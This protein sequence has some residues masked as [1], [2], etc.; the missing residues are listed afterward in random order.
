MFILFL[1][2]LYFLQV[3][4]FP[5]VWGPIP[6]FKLTNIPYNVGTTLYRKVQTTCCRLYIIHHILHNIE[7][8]MA[9]P[10]N[11]TILSLFAPSRFL[12]QNNERRNNKQLPVPQ[13][14]KIAVS[15]VIIELSYYTFRR[16]TL[17]PLYQEIS[18]ILMLY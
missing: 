2:T 18:V 14:A 4:L 16:L 15:L 6:T 13:K 9:Q 8:C 5:Q 7:L 3:R 1:V 17:A 12:Y 11:S 10:Y